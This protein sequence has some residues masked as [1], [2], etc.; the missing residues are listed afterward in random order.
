[1]SQESFDPLEL[2]V[3]FGAYHDGQLALFG[4][5]DD[6]ISLARH[7]LGGD[8]KEF[9][10]TVSLRQC[11]YLRDQELGILRPTLFLLSL[12]EALDFGSVRE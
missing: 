8:L 6:P 12:P 2:G 9:L 7:G 10:L 11:L 4:R 5:G 1:V 3:E